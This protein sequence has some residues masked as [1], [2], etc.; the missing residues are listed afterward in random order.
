[1]AEKKNIWPV[2]LGV[3]A[4]GGL[5]YA[6]SRKGGITGTPTTGTEQPPATTEGPTLPPQPSFP[7]P[8]SPPTTV[9]MAERVLRF[10]GYL[11]LYCRTGDRKYRDEAS[12]WLPRIYA[13]EEGKAPKSSVLTEELVDK[14]MTRY[15][16]W[17]DYFVE[18]QTERVLNLHVH[19]SHE[20]YE[21]TVPWDIAQALYQLM[22]CQLTAKRYD[23]SAWGGPRPHF[24][25]HNT[26]KGDPSLSDFALT[27]WSV[28]D[29]LADLRCP[30]EWVLLP[31]PKV[32]YNDELITLRFENKIVYSTGGARTEAIPVGIV[33]RIPV[34]LLR[35]WA[36]FKYGLKG[37][38]N[39]VSRPNASMTATLHFL[40]GASIV[41]IKLPAWAPQ[42]FPGYEDKTALRNWLA[43]VLASYGIFEPLEVV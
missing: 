17:M 12:I 25:P 13:P 41:P 38:G 39:I 2:V 32:F 7:A 28:A 35:Q 33:Q 9:P 23:L 11:D 20:K 40:M 37:A 6:L 31:G 27:L 8:P 4:A 29:A 10:V 34:A 3:V 19:D 43:G 21:K 14:L 36:P 1:M 16:V 5:A 26:W 15:N 24:Y 42:A 18:G 30:V 22:G